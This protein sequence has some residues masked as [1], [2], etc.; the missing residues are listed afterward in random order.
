[1]TTMGTKRKEAPEPEVVD[2]ADTTEEEGEEE[3]G[4]WKASNEAEELENKAE[5]EEQQWLSEK[6]RRIQEPLEEGELVEE[7]DAPKDAKAEAEAVAFGQKRAENIA[8]QT[9]A[10]VGVLKYDAEMASALVRASKMVDADPN[11][12]RHG[13]L[14]CE[15]HWCRQQRVSHACGCGATKKLAVFTSASA[16]SQLY[17]CMCC[18]KPICELCLAC[19]YHSARCGEDCGD[20]AAD[21]DFCRADMN[22]HMLAIACHSCLVAA[23]IKLYQ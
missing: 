7:E 5:A 10:L 4:E 3:E 1:M 13:T 2:T 12:N 20:A 9:E 8:K 22:E 14:M 6:W 19:S 18:H 17:E 23:K 15:C 16:F 11:G 21:S